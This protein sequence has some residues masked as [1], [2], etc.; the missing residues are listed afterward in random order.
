MQLYVDIISGY[1]LENLIS[2]SLSKK[3]YTIINNKLAEIIQSEDKV[4]FKLSK[5]CEYNIWTI[6]NDGPQYLVST[7][8]NSDFTIQ[9]RVNVCHKNSTE[10]QSG[11]I[12]KMADGSKY[13]FGSC[14]SDVIKLFCPEKESEPT[15]G[16]HAFLSDTVY[17]KIEK[18][19]FQYCFYY[20]KADNEA[21][22]KLCEVTSDEQ[23]SFAGLF[24]KTWGRIEFEVE[25]DD[26]L[27]INE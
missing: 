21:W 11:L 3:K 16:S 10:Y 19:N 15:L 1:D 14:C 24:S 25:F 7:K 12:L 4:I 2:E 26:F 13:L 5:D 20:K 6:L 17:L 8:D 18:R 22:I 9:A 27:F 23:V